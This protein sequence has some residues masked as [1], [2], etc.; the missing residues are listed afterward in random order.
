MLKFSF[1][2]MWSVKARAAYSI[3]RKYDRLDIGIETKYWAQTYPCKYLE[4]LLMQYNVYNLF[5]SPGE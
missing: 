5:L 4:Q 1:I 3:N 2:L